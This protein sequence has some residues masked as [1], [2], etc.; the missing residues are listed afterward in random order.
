M[1]KLFVGKLIS[2]EFYPDVDVVTMSDAETG[3]QKVGNLVGFEP[4]VVGEYDEVV[5]SF[6]RITKTRIG[7]PRLE[8]YFHMNIGLQETT[9]YGEFWPDH[10]FCTEK[11]QVSPPPKLVG[12]AI[13]VGENSL[14]TMAAR[15][16]AVIYPS[17]LQ[18][19]CK[20]GE[21]VEGFVDE[22]GVFYNRI[23]AQKVAVAS[24]QLSKNHEGILRS[25]DLWPNE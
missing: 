4:M 15:R 20:M 12:V 25:E 21:W 16:H 9:E 10:N 6:R 22:N 1:K 17:L 24:G 19:G 5:E 2:L 3:K 23:D 13:K 11:H 8:Q 14:H 7:I 18:L